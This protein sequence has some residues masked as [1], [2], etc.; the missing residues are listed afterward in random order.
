MRR[1]LELGRKGLG[2]TAPNPLV[3]C[4]IVHSGRIIGEGYHRAFGEA[5][6]EVNA[7]A[8]VKE[9]GLLPEST[10]YVNLEPCAHYGKTPPCT[11]LILEKKIPG[12]VIGTPDPNPL[13]KGK[14]IACLED[15]VVQVKQG[16][17]E[18]EC[19]GLNK[20]YFTF[21]QE[22]R[23]WILLKWAK[24]RDGF[25]DR[26]REGKDPG[27]V[28]WITG[29]EARQWVHRWRSEE[30]AI[31]VGTRTARID[32]PELTVRDWEGNNP[33]R[34][35]IDRKGTLPGGLKLFN[36]DADTLVF[37]SKPAS[38]RKGVKYVE[39][40]LEEDYLSFILSHL[41]DIGIQSLLVEGGATL[42]NSF[43]E[44]GIWDEARVFTG[45]PEFSSGIASPR[46]QVSPEEK[47]YLGG[48][49]L[50]IYRNRSRGNGRDAT[51]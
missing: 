16:V 28:N 35:I 27:G 51:K 15:G 38:P 46:I 48:D 32:D 7:I 37:T 14:G 9:S 26:N 18:S 1:C 42:L 19:R 36:D 20:R 44:Q 29:K 49:L 33:L 25:M 10:L 3:G 43:L 2:S 12:V 34:L 45:V 24:S 50:E 6:A 21:H 22:K 47:I 23:P 39:V 11:A 30:Q 17:L 40:P 13:V 4:V 8:S 41:H 5:H 31:L